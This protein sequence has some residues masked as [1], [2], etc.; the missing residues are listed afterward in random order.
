MRRAINKFK[1]AR[2]P[3]MQGG[4]SSIF[5]GIWASGSWTGFIFFCFLNKLVTN[6]GPALQ[7]PSLFLCY[8]LT[9]VIANHC[10]IFCILLYFILGEVLKSAWERTSTLMLF[11]LVL[12][13]VFVGFCLTPDKH[14]ALWRLKSRL[15]ANSVLLCYG[16]LKLKF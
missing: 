3:L 16:N 11:Q 10:R 9:S 12:D 6:W 7:F 1:Y 2:G 14:N 4:T 8:S 5:R 13:Q 15:V